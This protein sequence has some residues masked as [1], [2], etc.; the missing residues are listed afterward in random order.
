MSDRMMQAESDALNVAIAALCDQEG[1]YRV[2]GLEGTGK[3]IPYIGWYW[4][5]VDF[6]QPTFPVGDC[7]QF[8]GFMESNKWN[9]SYRDASPE[10][11][12]A[13]VAA[14]KQAVAAPNDERLQLVFDLIQALP[15][16]V[17]A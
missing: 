11:C 17:P 9:Y 1:T 13:I 4:R 14:L 12:A 8:A 10:R 6:T 3:V 16:E 5:E 7:G 2:R 15:L